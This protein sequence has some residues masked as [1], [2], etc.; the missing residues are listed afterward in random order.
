MN[1]LAIAINQ[2]TRPS[3]WGKI[4]AQRPAVA[5]PKRTT[6]QVAEKKKAILKA[7][8]SASQPCSARWIAEETGFTPRSVAHLLEKLELRGEIER[9]RDAS[10][11][12]NRPYVFWRIA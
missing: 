6:K 7:I 10:P 3:W 12:P 4:T 1:T 9:H 2:C 8:R 5:E 11:V